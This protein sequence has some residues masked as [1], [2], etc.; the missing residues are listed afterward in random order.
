MLDMN[1]GKVNR[2][3]PVTILPLA[4]MAVKWKVPKKKHGHNVQVLEYSEKKLIKNPLCCGN[5]EN[6]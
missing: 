4:L 6:R 2:S 5:F 3:L 1:H